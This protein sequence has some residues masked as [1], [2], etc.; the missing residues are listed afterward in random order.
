M[1]NQQTRPSIFLARGARRRGLRH[2]TGVSS[3]VAVG[4][5]ALLLGALAEAPGLAAGPPGGSRPADTAVGRAA[6]HLTWSACPYPG[7]PPS[8]QCASLRVPIDY[9]HPHG[10]HTTV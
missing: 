8:L 7:S 9:A 2:V 4:L 1:R 5:S 10:R 3:A 6:T